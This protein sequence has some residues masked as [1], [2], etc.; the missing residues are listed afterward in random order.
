MTPAIEYFVR[1][2]LIKEWFVLPTSLFLFEKSDNYR[3]VV[4][5]INN[6]LD[7]KD[8]Y[9]VKKWQL[10]LCSSEQALPFMTESR[11]LKG[12]IFSHPDVILENHRLVS[13]KQEVIN[14]NNNSFRHPMPSDLYDQLFQNTFENRIHN[15]KRINWLWK[16]FISIYAP[17]LCNNNNYIN[18]YYF[19]NSIADE[20]RRLVS[21]YKKR[22][23]NFWRVWQK[24]LL[25]NSGEL[26][27]S[28]EYMK[29]NN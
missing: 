13:Y 26:I 7:S 6:E 17:N 3:K 29:I 27:F 11:V 16:E 8:Y 18:T 12:E 24:H 21:K 22:Q 5:T 9:S 23:W 4:V 28:K 19:E 25:L 14:T 20:Q 15:Q 2:N 1:T 10:D